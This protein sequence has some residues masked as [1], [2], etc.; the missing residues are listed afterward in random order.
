MLKPAEKLAR[1]KKIAFK[2]LKFV[3]MPTSHST[4]EV[5]GKV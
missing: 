5:V 4:L 3:R 1:Q 2:E